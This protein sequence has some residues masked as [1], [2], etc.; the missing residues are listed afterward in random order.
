MVCVYKSLKN[1]IHK[2]PSGQRS[3]FPSLFA[4]SLPLSIHLS[5]LEP[6]G[7]DAGHAPHQ[8]GIPGELCPDQQAGAH[9]TQLSLLGCPGVFVPALHVHPS[10]TASRSALTLLSSVHTLQR[11]MYDAVNGSDLRKVREWLEVRGPVNCDNYHMAHCLQAV[12]SKT[13][14]GGWH[15]FA[16]A[17][18]CLGWKQGGGSGCHGQKE[19]RKITCMP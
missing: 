13:F 15:S 3:S 9:L 14:A 19:G 4:T 17:V 16:W 10:L 7:R 12:A 8:A 6:V 1:A 11:R 18:T 5:V 2:Q